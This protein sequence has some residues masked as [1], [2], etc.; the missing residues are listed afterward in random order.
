MR[1]ELK[2]IISVMWLCILITLVME[3]L[4]TISH[5]QELNKG[6]EQFPITTMLNKNILEKRV[7]KVKN[8]HAREGPGYEY[9]EVRRYGY[10]PYGFLINVLEE[11]NG[12][13]KFQK[14]RDGYYYT[15]W[16]EKKYTKKYI[17]RSKK[18][19]YGRGIGFTANFPKQ[20]TGVYLFVISNK[21]SLFIDY[22]ESGTFFEQRHHKKLHSYYGSVSINKAE[23]IFGDRLI[24]IEEEWRSAHIGLVKR[25]LNNLAIY[26]GIGGSWY[27][28][29]HQY[30]DELE[31]LSRNGNY[32]VE[33]RSKSQFHVGVLAGLLIQ[34]SP[35]IYSQIGGELNPHGITI[36]LGYGR[37][38]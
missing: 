16:I 14:L 8:V 11:K 10:I 34:L 22:K 38:R 6:T 27:N 30:H 3:S 24:K 37:L 1:C 5:T 29:Y 32:W 25:I 13:I 18:L 20:P 9:E 12:W 4:I 19:G 28:Q 23:N 35:K 21:A 26:S 2:R 7:C 33:N 31:I 36:G 17:K 15:L